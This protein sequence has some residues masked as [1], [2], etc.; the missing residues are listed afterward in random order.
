MEARGDGDK[1]AVNCKLGHLSIITSIHVSNDRRYICTAV[2]YVMMMMVMMIMMMVMIR[3]E[4]IRVSNLDKSYE[5]Q[6][7]L[8]YHT[9][10]ITS[11]C[12]CRGCLV[13]GGGDGNLCVWNMET[14][15]LYDVHAVSTQIVLEEK[16]SSRKREIEGM[17]AGLVP[18]SKVGHPNERIEYNRES[19]VIS[20][21]YSVGRD[22]IAVVVDALP[23]ILM[24]Q[25]TDS[26][27]LQ[28]IGSLSLGEGSDILPYGLFVDDDVIHAY[29]L[30]IRDQKVADHVLCR[31]SLITDQ[32]HV[33]CKF[34]P[35][36]LS[37]D[38]PVPDERLV[39][40]SVTS[41]AKINVLS[42]RKFEK[43]EE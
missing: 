39:F 24:Y 32:G 27:K 25:L 26:N 34:S 21:L 41:F 30:V 36:S 4:K 35:I 40:E 15:T 43:D 9:C 12:E 14:G 8:M 13:S 22:M 18:V 37:R 28:P 31:G 1:N 23:R 2:K 19:Y 29:G 6:S 10:F 17:P 38:I 7:Y 5:I 16:N 3:D 33:A 42:R 11:L 20:A